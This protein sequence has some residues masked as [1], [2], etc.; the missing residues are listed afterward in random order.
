MVNFKW[1][2]VIIHQRIDVRESSPLANINYDKCVP[3]SYVEKGKLPNYLQTVETIGVCIAQDNS[4][5]Y[6]TCK[7]KANILVPEIWEGQERICHRHFKPINIRGTDLTSKTFHLYHNQDCR[8]Y[9]IP[10][11]VANDIRHVLADWRDE[12]IQTGYG[13]T[14]IHISSIAEEVDQVIDI[15]DINKYHEST[16]YI[17]IPD[18]LMTLSMEYIEI[19]QKTEIDLCKKY[20]MAIEE[21]VEIGSEDL[22]YEEE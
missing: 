7:L 13:E 3:D 9:S 14:N 6:F 22:K 17:F 4:R 12:D 16:N 1:K 2:P 21:Y 10:R 5:D 15:I 8:C 19:K 20:K 11:G 18:Y